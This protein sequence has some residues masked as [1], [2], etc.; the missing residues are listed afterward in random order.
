MSKKIVFFLCA[1]YTFTP[2]FVEAASLNLSPAS[3]SYSVGK[4]FSVNVVLNSENQA[5][6]AASGIVSF[7]QDLIEVVTLSKQGS[8]FS[9]WPSEPTFSNSQGTVSFE[10]IV[11]NPGYTGSGGK[12]IGITFRIRSSGSARLNFSSGSILANDGSGTNIL[13]DLRS[14]TFSLT[15]NT[16]ETASISKPP[17]S[18]SVTNMSSPVTII[19]STH[20]DQGAW[21]TNNTPEFSWVL[22]ED[23]LEVRTLIGTSPLGVPRVSYKPA[24]SKKKVDPLPDGTYYFSIQVRTKAGWGSISRYQVNIDTTPPQSF[25]VVFPHGNTSW[26]PQPIVYFNT[27]DKESGISHYDI[28]VGREAQPVK[29]APVTQSN[30]YLLPPQLPGTYTLFVTAIDKAGN[31]KTESTQFTIEGIEA[32]K[33][34]YVPDVL[35]EGDILKV[36]GTTYQNADIFVYIKE[37]ELLI[38][39]ERTRSNALGDFALVATKRLDAGTYTITARVKDARGAQSTETA[40]VTIIIR[41]EFVSEITSSVFKYLIV[42]I[43]ILVAIG[44]FVLTAIFIWF[45]IVRTMRRMRHEAKEAEHVTDQAFRVLRERI[46]THVEK[47][48][49]SNKKLTKNEHAFLEEFEGMLGEANDVI[50]KEIKDVIE[51]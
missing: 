1:V 45:K 40:P 36:R 4:T 10:G 12:I 33:L 43:S 51:A 32:P 3:G 17:S 13:Q 50:S 30:P 20:P 6:N 11:L 24:I 37:G 8:I 26:E 22:G 27:E 31:I 35:E 28:K 38:S 18:E 25:S 44:L 34:S 39:E 41:S 46:I 23:A 42:G 5:M 47:L 16:E 9:L 15:E 14:A 7:P 49:K 48:K 19:S 29:V 2:F 21:Y